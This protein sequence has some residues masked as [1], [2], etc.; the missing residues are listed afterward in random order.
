MRLDTGSEVPGAPTLT[1]ADDGALAAAWKVQIHGAGA[2][3]LLERRADGTPN[4]AIVAAPHGGAVGQLAMGGSHR[5]DAIFGFLQGSGANAQI[6]AVVVRAPPGAF[7]ADTPNGWIKA[8]HIPL[9]W[10][11]P[12]A[13][14]GKI[15]Y[16]ILVDDREVVEGIT[17]NEYLLNSEQVG[18]GVHS[19]QIEATDSI[20]QVVDSAPS[21][22]KVART[23]PR[24][25]VSVRGASVTVRLS[26]P[27]KGESPGVR[28][29]SVKVGFGD[30]H[31]ARGRTT[32]AHTYSRAGTYTI[33]VSAS[34]NA[35][36]KTSFHKRV[37]VS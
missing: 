37:R 12:Q 20:G 10:E 8:T 35:G 31:S 23:G 6:A 36:N 14:A 32:L 18:N 22:L 7:V 25:R 16:S 34:D 11:V 5:G 29:G 4:R 19:I 21:T 28:K 24:V 17:G 9:Q 33:V 26:D 30:G 2:V 1:R 3:A 15:T 13:G 27:P